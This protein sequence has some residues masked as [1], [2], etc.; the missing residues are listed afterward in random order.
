M[1]NIFAVAAAYAAALIGAGF[2]SGQETVAFFVKYGKS[3]FFGIILSAA[4]FGF[5][6]AV[7]LSGCV[8]SRTDSYGEYLSRLMNEKIRRVTEAITLFFSAVVFCVMASCCGEMGHMIFGVKKYVGAFVI[9]V[10]CGII[11]SFK[12]DSALNVNAVTGGALVIGIIT[13]CLYLLRYREHQ[14]FLNSAPMLLSAVS[15][16]GY[17]LLTAAAVLCPLSARLKTR[18][19]AYLSAFAGA[20]A[21]FVIMTL[22]WAL[23]SIYYGKIP[24]GEIPV[25]TLAM[26]ENRGIAAA[27]SA[28]L[29]AAVFSTALSNGIGAV[30]IIGGD[31]KTIAALIAAVGFL[32]SSAGFSA[33]VNNLYRICGYIGIIFF[34]YILFKQL[35]TSKTAKKEEKRSK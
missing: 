14:A 17:N 13:C 5:F 26:R 11:M 25:L 7:V 4:V 2:A 6:A 21:L 28:V 35:R 18:S 24:L 20:F 16:S 31:R 9:C 34:A 30:N 8:A 3:G 23:I 29:F 15:Y 32:G 10:T 12:T 1:K 22:M 33:L 27:Y 19:D